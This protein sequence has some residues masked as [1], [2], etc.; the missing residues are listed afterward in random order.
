MGTRATHGTTPCTTL[1][2]PPPFGIT[3]RQTKS[4]P[5]GLLKIQMLPSMLLPEQDPQPPAIRTAPAPPFGVRPRA[6][7]GAAATDVLVAGRRRCPRLRRV[8]GLQP[9][10]AGAEQGAVGG[11]AAAAALP[12]LVLLQV[13][14]QRSRPLLLPRRRLQQGRGAVGR[15]AAQGF[16]VGGDGAGVPG[17]G[18][19]GEDTWQCTLSPG[20]S[21]RPPVG[22]SQ[23]PVTWSIL[24]P[25]QASP[26][27]GA[28]CAWRQA[29]TVPGAAWQQED[30]EPRGR[31]HR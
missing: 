29:E 31:N 28:V 17:A 21:L 5:G 22:A 18:R 3:R 2:P 11:A 7:S 24:Q 4:S 20:A 9:G 12:A 14:V 23:L 13:V 8:L 15:S 19:G 30:K 6:P 25:H 27:P 1:E 16:F 10:G 26:E